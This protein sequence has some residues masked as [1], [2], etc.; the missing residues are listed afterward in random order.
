MR[1]RGGR[2]EQQSGHL[3]KWNW[4]KEERREGRV[5]GRMEEK[6]QQP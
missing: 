2:G 6:R 5:A 3:N 4:W 1:S